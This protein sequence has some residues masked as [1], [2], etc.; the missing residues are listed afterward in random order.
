MASPKYARF[1]AASGLVR[2]LSPRTRYY[3]R[4]RVIDPA[5]GA[6]LSPYTPKTYPSATTTGVAVPSGLHVADTSAS[7][8]SLTW[9]PS[10]GATE[11]RVA[12]STSPT[13]SSSTYFSSTTASKTIAGLRPGTTYYVHTRSLGTAGIT[14]TPYS[15]PTSAQTMSPPA[16]A[17]TSTGPYDLRVGSFNVM[18]VTGDQTVGDRLPWAQRRATV[19]KEIL[20]EKV[21]IIGVQEVNQS[22]TMASHL[23]DGGTQFLDLKNGLNSAGGTY[24][25]TNEDSYNCVRPETSYKCVYQDRGASGGDR[26]YYNTSTLDKVSQGAYRYQ[27]QDAGASPAGG[28]MLTYAVMQVKATGARFLF[29]STHLDPTNPDVKMAQWHELIAKVN[30]LKGSLPVVSVGD[31]NTQKND[32]RAQEMLPAMKD[33]GYGDVLNQ[34]AFTNPVVNP[35]AEKTINGW[36][37]SLGRYNRDTTT[38]SYSTNHAKTGNS[39]DWIFASNWLPVREYKVVLDYDPATLL[40]RGVI[41]SDHNMIRATLTL[42]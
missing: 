9:T 19:V 4:V 17:I 5:T 18:T 21:D 42:P 1:T 2:N 29:T 13:F 10:E 32:V 35:R 25:L 11:Y 28:W 33:A 24:A 15:A 20:G 6:G 34:T 39:I 38:Y 40:V 30:E 14:G 22:Y 41:P 16:G 36:F 7:S 26:I 3:F 31:F 27:A 12:V 23:V 37:N 8:V